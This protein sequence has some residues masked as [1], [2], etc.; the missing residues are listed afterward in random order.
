[1]LAVCCDIIIPI[2]IMMRL[3]DSQQFGRAVRNA[4][5]GRGLRQEDVALA[6]GAG[7]RFVSELERGKP[8]AR[9]DL[10]LRVAMAAGLRLVA[11]DDDA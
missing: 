6:S 10:A 5:K 3:T 9:L 8:T 11:E 7:L 2:G 4:R 1:M